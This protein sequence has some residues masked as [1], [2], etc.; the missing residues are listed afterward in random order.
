M[1]SK[2]HKK[3]LRDSD[4]IS[5]INDDILYKSE[6][7]LFKSIKKPTNKNYSS[8]IKRKNDY[9]KAKGKYNLGKNVYNVA[10]KESVLSY[11]KHSF[12]CKCGMCSL[13]RYLN[14]IERKKYYDDLFKQK[15]ED[16]QGESKGNLLEPLVNKQFIDL[17]ESTVMVYKV[18]GLL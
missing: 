12:S 7:I 6:G 17:N 4:I 16:Y 11:K 15:M 9:Y 8:D 13:E 1:T 14:K 10:K 5:Q 2:K 3:F 18:L